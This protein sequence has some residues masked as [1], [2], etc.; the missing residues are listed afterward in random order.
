MLCKDT[1]VCIISEV[2]CI[3]KEKG[4]LFGKWVLYSSSIQGIIAHLLSS[5]RRQTI[6]WE[7]KICESVN[8]YLK[9]GLE[10]A[11]FLSDTGEVSACLFMS[12]MVENLLS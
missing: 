1:H 4:R 3:D 11:I 9:G 6:C 7:I 12:P 5:P 2:A 8:L 10:K